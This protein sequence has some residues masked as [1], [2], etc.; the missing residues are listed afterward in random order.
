MFILDRPA[1]LQQTPLVFDLHQ[2]CAIAL[3]LHI[4]ETSTLL[5][6]L[7]IGALQDFDFTIKRIETLTLSEATRQTG[8]LT[9]RLLSISLLKTLYRN[10]AA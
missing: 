3:T 4:F 7:C 6:L 8:T 9:V 10:N 5:Q 2:L 1:C